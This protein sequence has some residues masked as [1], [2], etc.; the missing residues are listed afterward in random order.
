M[1]ESIII[2]KKT[3]IKKEKEGRREG[4]KEGRNNAHD[5]YYPCFRCRVK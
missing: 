1:S 5:S 3:K 2:V 4:G